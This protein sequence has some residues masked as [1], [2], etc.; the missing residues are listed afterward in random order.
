[1]YTS[2][3]TSLWPPEAY[4]R[5]QATVPLLWRSRRR[6]AVVLITRPDTDEFGRRTII[7]ARIISPYRG[8]S[9][10]GFS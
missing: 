8:K 1:M 2:T 10:C 3:C 9:Y 6:L 4:W 5:V 7:V